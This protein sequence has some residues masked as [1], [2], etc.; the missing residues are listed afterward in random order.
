MNSEGTTTH[1]YT[2]VTIVTFDA[3]IVQCFCHGGHS[4]LPRV[5]I[6]DQLEEADN[7]GWLPPTIILSLRS[8]ALP[9]ITKHKTDTGQ[10]SGYYAT[11]F[12]GKEDHG[13]CSISTVKH[14][15]SSLRQQGMQVILFASVSV[16]FCAFWM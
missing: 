8:Y 5:T 4:L 11:I 3:V 13:L 9:H 2:T 16:K 6:G 15:A 7:G 12:S 1:T 10:K 14:F